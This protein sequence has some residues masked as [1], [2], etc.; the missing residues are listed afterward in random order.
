MLLVG[1]A[2]QHG[3][4]P[5]SAAAIERAIELNGA[6]VETNLAAFRWGRAW[7]VDPDAIAAAIAPAA[8]EPERLD[9]RAAAIVDGVGADGELRRLLEV[10][11]PELIAYQDEAYARRYA[12]DVARVLAV[13][14]E[15]TGATV[16]AEAYARGLF[17]LLA[18]KDEYEVARLHLHAAE[19]ARREDA[20]GADAKVRILLH[21]PVL[22]AMGL[23]RKLKLGPWVL[24]LL[25][26]LRASRR[27]R[28]TALDPF[29]RAQVRRVERE[30]I[31]EYRAVID[32][33]L[34]GLDAQNANVVRELAELPDVIRGYEDIKLRNV[35]RFRARA[36]EL[37]S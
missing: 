3:C 2:F 16:I 31:D 5:V 26:G 1:A 8:T 19:R 23:E 30:L 20:F 12:D 15:R 9:A 14:R 7:I 17:K 29:G 28:G 24:P 34:A 22:R 10:R 4:L 13:E 18:Y 36:R 37:T 11:V 33:A 25:R 32:E 35:E 6:A 27:L 21:P